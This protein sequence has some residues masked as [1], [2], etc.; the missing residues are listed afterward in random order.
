MDMFSLAE[1]PALGQ[2]KSYTF[3]YVLIQIDTEYLLLTSTGIKVCFTASIEK[4]TS[5]VK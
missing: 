4:V 2:V 1:T 5:F 3:I